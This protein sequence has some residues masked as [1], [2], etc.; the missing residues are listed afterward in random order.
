MKPGQVL[1]LTYEPFGFTNKL[2]RI[3]NLNFNA[4]CTTSIKA[5]EYDDS[6]HFI[7]AQQKTKLFSENTGTELKAK[8][9]GAPTNFTISELSNSP[10]MLQLSWTNATDFREETDFT[11]VWHDSSNENDRSIATRIATVKGETFNFYQSEPNTDNFFWVRH[12]R[13][14]DGVGKAKQILFSAYNPTSATAG[15]QITPINLNLGFVKVDK[16]AVNIALDAG[17]AVSTP[18]ITVNNV[19]ENFGTLNTTTTFNLLELDGTTAAVG[20]T[21]NNGSTTVTGNS[22][23]IASG[24]VTPTTTPK[25]LRARTTIGQNQGPSSGATFDAFSSV[26]IQRSDTDQRRKTGLLYYFAGLPT[27]DANGKATIKGQLTG[28]SV[29]Y[30]F[31]TQAFSGLTGTNWVEE[32]PAIEPPASQSSTNK[33]FYYIRYTLTEIT[34]GLSKGKAVMTL[35]TLGTDFSSNGGTNSFAVGDANTFVDFTRAVRFTDIENDTSTVIH[36]SNITTGSIQ[37]S[38]FTP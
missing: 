32:P 36:G 11:E 14:Q 10:G 37:S 18:N 33:A 38:G 13:I 35:N 29:S 3:Q 16:P 20:C 21:F 24:S 8:A 4:D 22:A 19:K 25:L 27:Q 6:V 26:N 34:T 23:T 12:K 2:F 28:A 17:G 31:D 7:S 1:G 15:T 9:P 30:N 5:I